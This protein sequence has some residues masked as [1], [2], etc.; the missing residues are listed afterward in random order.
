MS[1]AEVPPPPSKNARSSS[2][3][4]SS[5][6]L[7]NVPFL[8]FKGASSAL[9]LMGPARPSLSF[10]YVLLW[11]VKSIF[12]SFHSPLFKVPILGQPVII[13]PIHPAEASMD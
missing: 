10:Q 6:P 13:G 8:N 12:F 4:S 9:T 5:F 2:G 3:P 7:L 11:Y 1:L